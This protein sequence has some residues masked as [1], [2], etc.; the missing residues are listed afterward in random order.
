MIL[1]LAVLIFPGSVQAEALRI[2]Y[3]EFK[4][5]F[6]KPTKGRWKGSSMKS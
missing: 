5:F 6:T 1:C 2:A 4:P 3:P